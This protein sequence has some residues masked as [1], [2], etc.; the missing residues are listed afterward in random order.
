MKF[1]E[2]IPDHKIDKARKSIKLFFLG[3]ISKNGK[4]LNFLLTNYLVIFI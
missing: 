3:R 4:H 1:V 2:F